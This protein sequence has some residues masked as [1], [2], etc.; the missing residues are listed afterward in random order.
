MI[1]FPSAS[2]VSLVDIGQIG[3]LTKHQHT[4]IGV[5]YVYD[6]EDPV[7]GEIYLEY[8]WS[9]VCINI[10]ILQVNGRTFDQIFGVW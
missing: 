5:L 9:I 8:L 4:T 6:L 7:K 10:H 2:E 3:A 1:Q